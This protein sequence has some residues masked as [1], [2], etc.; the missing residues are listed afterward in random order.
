MNFIQNSDIEQEKKKN[1]FY[2]NC[3]FSFTY[4]LNLLDTDGSPHV[5]LYIYLMCTVIHFTSQSSEFTFLYINIFFILILKKT[6]KI[7]II[8]YLKKVFI[9]WPAQYLELLS[10][11]S[12]IT[13]GSS[14]SSDLA[15]I[16]VVTFMNLKQV[17]R[18]LSK[19][20]EFCFGYWS[21]PR[22]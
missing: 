19:I 11:E 7:M 22:F 3:I 8:I 17:Q 5:V 18:K 2:M 1:Y 9:F 20:N 21:Y 6:L 15:E 16:E 4:S 13:L 12:L 14:S 10:S